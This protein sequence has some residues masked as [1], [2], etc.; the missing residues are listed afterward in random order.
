MRSNIARTES[1]GSVPVPA[2]MCRRSLA[3]GRLCAA[4]ALT[5]DAALLGTALEGGEEVDERGLL[6]L[7]QALEGRHRRGRILERAA[8][9]ATLEL[10]TDVGQVRAGAVIAVLADLVAG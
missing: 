7:G 9:R 5:L 2:P 1:A 4:A 6:V 3:A 8:D 10:V